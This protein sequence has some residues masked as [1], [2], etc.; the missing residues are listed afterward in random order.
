MDVDRYI[1]ERNIA[2]YHEGQDLDIAFLNI[3]SADA[4][5][6]ILPLWQESEPGSQINQWAGQWLAKQYSGLNYEMSTNQLPFS[7]NLARRAAW[8][9]L[10]AV[11]AQLPAYDPSLYW[12]SYYSSYSESRSDYQ[13]GWESVATAAPGGE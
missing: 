11:S 8:G 9:E 13:S 1:A 7:L 12:G 5:P 2:R 10:Q 6:A 4:V 3:L